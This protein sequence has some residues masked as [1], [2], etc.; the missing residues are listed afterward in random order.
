MSNA[1]PMP[2]DRMPA[3]RTGHGAASVI[4]HLNDRVELEPAHLDESTPAQSYGDDETAA[5]P[6]EADQ[7]ERD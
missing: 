1:L 2:K 4:P 3:P 7:G 5:D 6:R